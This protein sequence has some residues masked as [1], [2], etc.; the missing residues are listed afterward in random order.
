M[1]A[2]FHGLS[3]GE[4]KLGLASNFFISSVPHHTWLNY[5]LELAAQDKDKRTEQRRQQA[6]ESDA[7]MSGV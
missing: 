4:G 5:S 1:S 2:T 6:T 3:T 7:S